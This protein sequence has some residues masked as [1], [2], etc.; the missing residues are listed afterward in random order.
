MIYG[1]WFKFKELKDDSNSLVINLKS[2]TT[3]SD[4]NYFSILSGLKSILIY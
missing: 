1:D 3:S 4:K 2:N